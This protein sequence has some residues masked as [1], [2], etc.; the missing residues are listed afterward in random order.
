MGVQGR[1]HHGHG[2]SAESSSGDQP[3]SAASSLPAPSLWGSDG[4]GPAASCAVQHGRVGPCSSPLVL[5]ASP[6]H[7]LC[8]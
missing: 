3:P 1:H 6:L 7:A 8:C 4:A 2:A 5:R